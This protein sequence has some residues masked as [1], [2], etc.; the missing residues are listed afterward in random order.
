VTDGTVAAR[1][2][3]RVKRNNETIFQGS[4]L[5]L[6]HYQDSVAEVKEGQ[7]CGL[8]VDSF[9]DFHEGDVLEFYEVEV[10]KQ[11]L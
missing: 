7:E 8:R 1:H 11:A 10:L 5:S 9:G 6:K 3:V 2:K 4:V